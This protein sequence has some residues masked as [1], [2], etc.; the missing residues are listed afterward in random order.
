MEDD[1]HLVGHRLLERCT[2]GHVADDP[3]RWEPREERQIG[4]APMKCADLPAFLAEA[5]D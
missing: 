5:L 1:I 4:R 2:I 3:L